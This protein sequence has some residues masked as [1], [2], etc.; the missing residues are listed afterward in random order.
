MKDESVGKELAKS[1]KE[2]KWCSIEYL[3][4]DDIITCYWIAIKNVS[5]TDKVL[6]CA[7]FNIAKLG[8]ESS[9][10][11]DINIYFEKIRRA[12]CINITSYEQNPNLIKKIEE[13]IELLNW[14]NYDI[15]KDDLINYLKACLEYENIS[16]S[17]EQAL[18]SK[19]D[20]N[21]LSEASRNGEYH[22]SLSQMGEL[23]SKLENLSKN[24]EKNKLLNRKL[25]INA[26]SLQVKQGLF[27][28]AYRDV[29]FD[30]SKRSLVID[31]EIKF[32]Y[33]FYAN[34]KR[35]YRYNL[36]N[37]LDI[38]IEDFVNIFIESPEK[39]KNLLYKELN[40]NLEKLNDLP[41][42]MEDIKFSHQKLY[43]DLDEI[44]RNIC[45]NQ[46][47]VPLKAFFGNMT[48]G[49]SKNRREVKVILLDKMANIDQLR[50]IYNALVQPITYVQ[51][52]P[53]TGKTFTNINVIIAAYCNSQTVLVSSNNN[54][55]INDI[56]K[57]L[58]SLKYRDKTIPFPALR[59]GNREETLNSLNNL[60]IILEECKNYKPIESSLNNLFEKNIE[61]FKKINELLMRYEEQIELVE[62]IDVLRR[63]ND[64]VDSL[65]SNILTSLQLEKKEKEYNDFDKVNELDVQ[66]LVN[67]ADESFFTWLFFSSIKKLK[68]LE[69][70]KNI[71]LLDIINSEDDDLKLKKFDLYMQDSENI[72]KLLAIF[73]VILTT[74][75]SVQKIGIV[76]PYFDLAIIDE[77]SQCT[78]AH[79]LLVLGRAHRLLLVGDEK[80][81]R[82][83]ANIPDYSNQKMMHR[84]NIPE[85]Y[86]YCEKS[87]L[88]VMQQNDTTSKFVMLSYHYRSEKNI[89]NFSNH[90]YYNNRLKVLTET[91]KNPDVLQYISVDQSNELYPKERNTSI[92]EINAIIR[93]IKK[94]KSENVAIITP[95]RNQAD[96]FRKSL[97]QNGLDKVQV[98]TI[99]TFQGDEK[100]T[101]YF[102]TSLNRNTNS[103]VFSWAANNMELINVAA[104]RAKKRFVL[105]CDDKEIEGRCDTNDD[106]AQL[107]KYVKSNGREIPL[108]KID[109]KNYINGNN[110]KL[111]NTKA[112]LEFFETINHILSF[113]DKF[114][115][116]TKVRVSSLIAKISKEN[117]D[118][119]YRAEFDLVIFDS[120]KRPIAVF[121]LDGDE[122]STKKGIAKDLK[123]EKI[124][125]DNNIIIQHIK[126]DFSRRYIF[127][128]DILLQLFK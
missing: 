102:S 43:N 77:A 14:L 87:I 111:Y 86:N 50:V 27:V 24:E 85:S 1:I 19:V 121:E 80:Q 22:L 45:L 88:Q 109:D 122:H 62:E 47:N 32:N 118:Y 51:G 25:I 127:L 91:S 56:L 100:E 71:K 12:Q 113:S 55:P 116:E 9:G 81:L 35:T 83:I 13:N 107:L 21:A 92:N 104:T 52:P 66:N 38:E 34:E 69:K 70:E 15:N 41:Y 82:P 58:Y 39:A 61:K 48:K 125:R 18:I 44:K 115:Y 73:P 79:S 124:C 54:K 128:K 72:K 97:D 84:F 94:N 89:I 110:Y 29:C 67:K 65:K 98:G 90:R 93:D 42:L 31:E 60:K 4:K 11:I 10:L 23:V 120:L 68:L 7:A 119:G 106:L 6:S 3:N 36:K 16:F 59:L 117:T 17:N 33:D 57:K 5:L 101:I 64:K 2:Q 78:I 108:S 95:F 105:V 75:Q 20:I 99:H 40:S 28:I 63:F 8:N 76:E 49:F 103:K 74:N 37:Y 123:K 30:P 112:E 114:T 46:L 53:G 26:L 126:N 96:N